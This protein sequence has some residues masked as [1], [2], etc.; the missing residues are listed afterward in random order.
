[1]SKSFRVSIFVTVDRPYQMSIVS[2]IIKYARE[3]GNWSFSLDPFASLGPKRFTSGWKGDGIIGTISRPSEAAAA[4]G[5]PTVNVAGSAR[6]IALPR[7]IPDNYQIGRLAAWHLV[8]RGF[9]QF[10]CVSQANTWSSQLRREGFVDL[11]KE[12]DLEKNL[13]DFSVTVDIDTCNE[14]RDWNTH[15]QMLQEWVSSLPKTIGV[16]ATNDTWSRR[17]ALACEQLE[18]SIPD[19]LALIGAENEVPICEFSDP[20]LSS[21]DAGL[22][23]VG[24]R[25]AKLLDSLM[26]GEG[27]PKEPILIPPVGVVTRQ[28]TDILAIEDPDLRAAVRFIHDHAHEPIRITNVLKEVSISRRPLEQRFRKYLHR[29]FNEEINR[30]HV[31]RAKKLLAETNMSIG[32]VAE[33]SGL[34][35]RRQLTRVFAQYVGMT[36]SAYRKKACAPSF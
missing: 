15:Q 19:D 24:Y 35:R 10:G 26:R 2:G 36:P 13:S 32:E 16:L 22:D 30:I 12:H 21:I 28:S 14:D 9:R 11:L 25:A 1:M 27:T 31:E 3:V 23:K 5:I 20:S 18:I 4:D 34:V 29:S 33:S 6:D 8:E 17:V 7:V